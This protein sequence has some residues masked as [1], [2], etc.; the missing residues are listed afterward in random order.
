MVVLEKTLESPLDSKGIKPVN[1][2]G[3]Q[4]WIV[5]GRTDAEAEAPVLWIPGMKSWLWKEPWCWERLRARREE[6]WQRMRWLDGITKS[7]DMNLSRLWEIVK[8]REA[9]CAAVHGAARGRT[10]LSCWTT[11]EAKGTME[12]GWP[13]SRLAI[14]VW[15]LEQRVAVFSFIWS[16]CQVLLGQLSFQCAFKKPKLVNFCVVVLILKMEE[17]QYFCH[18]M[19]YYLKKW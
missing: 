16:N 1:P 8:D 5:I 2:K 17:K 7:V 12:L 14:P 19:L 11:A 9:W 15:W 10:Q 3:N 13:N 18:I 6:G 4:S